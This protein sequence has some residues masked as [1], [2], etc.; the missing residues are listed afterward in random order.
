MSFRIISWFLIVFGC[1][2]GIGSTPLLDNNEGMY[3]SIAR[4]MLDNGNFIIPHLAGVPY[5]EKPPMLYWLM[6]ASMSLFGRNEWAVHLV[7]AL[8]FFITAF[9]LQRFTRKTTGND[10]LGLFAALMLISSLPMLVFGRQILCD[11]IMTCFFSIAMFSFFTWQQNSNKRY[12]HL[13]YGSLA[14]AA[15]S[16]GLTT[17]ILAGGIIGSFYLWERKPSWHHLKFLSPLGIGLFLLIAAPW[18]IA[19]TLQNEDF[20]WFYFVNEHWLRFINQR[21]PHDY[22]TGAWWY[23]LPKILFYLIPWTLFLLIFTR[24]TKPSHCSY[25]SLARFLW[26]WFLFCLVFFS[27]AGSKANYYMIVGMPPLV[28]LITLYLK[29]FMD[30]GDRVTRSLT[31]GAFVCLFIM[32]WLMYHLCTNTSTELLATCQE[33]SWIHIAVGAVYCL[34]AIVLSWR[35]PQHWLAPLLGSHLLL[36]LPLLIASVESFGEK[37]SQKEMA[38]Y[39]QAGD[40]EAVAMYQEFEDISAFAFYV[41]KPLLIVDSQSADLLYGQKKLASQ[42]ATSSM[43]LSLDEWAKRKPAVPMVVLKKNLYAAMDRLRDLKVDLQHVCIIKRLGRVAV[44][45]MCEHGH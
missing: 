11:M 3:A 9:S 1:F 21:E 16:K 20:A 24:N 30:K 45:N 31:S 43:F 13:F 7:P 44:I 22:H 33:I 15:L 37:L 25:P 14:L 10:T 19:A 29:P 26:S 17:C 2:Y 39:V 42:P 28:M 38:E 6:A 18:H 32:V 27:I 40:S 12:L 41:K 35:L 23:Y 8:A 4:D 34:I 36:M 5:L